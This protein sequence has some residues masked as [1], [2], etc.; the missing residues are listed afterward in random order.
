MLDYS[1]FLR[2]T[3]E[4]R[5]WIFSGLFVLVIPLLCSFEFESVVILHATLQQRVRKAQEGE[6][7]AQFCQMELSR[8]GMATLWYACHRWHAQ[9]I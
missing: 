3:Y 6:S 2:C 7:V 5:F 1:D 8:P 9:E 4:P